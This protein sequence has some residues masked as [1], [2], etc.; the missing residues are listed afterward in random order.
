W[1]LTKV[2]S[3]YGARLCVERPH[4]Q[5]QRA[6]MKANRSAIPP[7][8]PITA[9]IPRATLR[10]LGID[11]NTAE[12]RTTR[13]QDAV[14][15]FVENGFSDVG[16]TGSGAVVKEW[17]EKGGARLLESKGGPIKHMIASTEMSEADVEKGRHVMR[18]LDNSQ[19]GPKD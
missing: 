2:S 10:D 5:T 15:F 18:H 7:P 11:A 14:P 8:A 13:Y 3:V 17:Q 6:N 12:I 4:A 16:I 19:T 9:V 1:T